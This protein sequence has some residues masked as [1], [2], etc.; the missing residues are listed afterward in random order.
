MVKSIP[1]QFAANSLISFASLIAVWS[2]HNTII[3]FGLCSNSLVKANGVPS[4]VTGI[5]EDPVVSMQIPFMSSGFILPFLTT[6]L[7]V[8]SN[9]SIWSNGRCV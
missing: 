9:P 5:G 6:A 4:F 1:P 2:F 3:A 7:T 8:F